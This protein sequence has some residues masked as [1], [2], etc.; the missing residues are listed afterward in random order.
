MYINVRIFF[1]I[2]LAAGTTWVSHRDCA[3]SLPEVLRHPVAHLITMR[4]LAA[5]CPPPPKKKRVTTL[6]K[7]TWHRGPIRRCRTASDKYP[8]VHLN[9]TA[10]SR[11]LTRFRGTVYRDTTKL[12]RPSALAAEKR[13]DV[14]WCHSL[15]GKLS[16]KLHRAPVNP[17]AVRKFHLCSYCIRVVHE[18]KGSGRAKSSQYC[19]RFRFF[20]EETV[21]KCLI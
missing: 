21:V 15:Q 8:A 17:R 16:E 1:F 4:N 14:R 11:V 18:L 10:I 5:P 9:K 19:K 20:V 3:N 2:L 12:G 7:F 6:P 13:E